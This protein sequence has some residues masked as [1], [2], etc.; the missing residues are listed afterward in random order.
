MEAD[1]DRTL[2]QQPETRSERPYEALISAVLH[3]AVRDAAHGVPAGLDVEAID[4]P[5]EHLPSIKRWAED[6]NAVSAAQVARIIR[7]HSNQDNR[8]DG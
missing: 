4:P 8:T 2:Y 6:S 7:R 3:R 5:E 1:V